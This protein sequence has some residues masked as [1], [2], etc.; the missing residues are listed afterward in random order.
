MYIVIF[1]GLVLIGFTY[2]VFKYMGY[3]LNVFIESV[4]VDIYMSLYKSPKKSNGF[5]D[6]PYDIQKYILRNV[7][8]ST[9]CMFSII[10][11]KH[12][13]TLGKSKECY[14]ID[15]LFKLHNNISIGNE[16]CFE[17]RGTNMCD[18][19]VTLRQNGTLI[20]ILGDK[21][22]K[23]VRNMV[24]IMGFANPLWIDPYD[25]FEYHQQLWI[26]HED[27]EKA[28]RLLWKVRKENVGV[29]C[30]FTSEPVHSSVKYCVDS[31]IV[32]SSIVDSSIIDSSVIKEVISLCSV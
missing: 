29:F 5:D 1:F 11:K 23:E 30:V 15:L 17:M 7:N 31:S 26:S 21:N 27:M 9:Q 13:A 25:S 12:L 16:V 8:C 20:D 6:L 22:I 32:D 3:D 14:F 18:L 10:S 2:D 4:C 24:D 28:Y 19:F